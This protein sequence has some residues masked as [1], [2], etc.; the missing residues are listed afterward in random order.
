MYRN[1]TSYRNAIHAD[2]E[3]LLA[4]EA[5]HRSNKTSEQWIL[6]ERQAMCDAVNRLRSLH[7]KP[8]VTLAEIERVERSAVGH[9]D[10]AH[11]FALYC[12]ELVEA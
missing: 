3:E 1:G 5:K 4:R 9:S 8:V 11:K 2:L 12:A 7:G 6:D 10:Y